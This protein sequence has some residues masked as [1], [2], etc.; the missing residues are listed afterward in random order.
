[1]QTNV[2]LFLNFKN[3]VLFVQFRNPNQIFS[4]ICA[5]V[6][7]ASINW[8]TLNYEFYISVISKNNFIKT[9]NI[10]LTIFQSLVGFIHPHTTQSTKF[11]RNDL[12]LSTVQTL[13]QKIIFQ[14]V[15][16]MNNKLFNSRQS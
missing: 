1:M 7:N 9:C 2:F 11:L 3:F 6:L 10:I 16:F 8:L 4:I 15:T 12:Y 14:C 5:I 13:S